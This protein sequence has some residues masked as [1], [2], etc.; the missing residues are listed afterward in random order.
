MFLFS[1]SAWLKKIAEEKKNRGHDQCPLFFYGIL[2]P[3][4][5]NNFLLGFVQDVELFADFYK[6]IQG[7][8][9][10]VDFMGGRNLGPDSGLTLRNHREEEA[11]GVNSFFIKSLGEFLS[12]PGIEEHNRNDRS[13]AFFKDEP[14]F[15]Q[16]FS[17]VLGVL[18][19]LVAALGGSGKNFQHLQDSAN[20][21]RS[22]GVGEKIRSGFLPAHLHDFR[23]T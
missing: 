16:A 6:S 9:Q 12:Q 10:V 21:Y 11:D 18:F 7:F 15:R 22:N 17:P 14:G 1:P 23:P 20:D 4:H 19:Q 8:V 3:V 5:L 2:H 13:V